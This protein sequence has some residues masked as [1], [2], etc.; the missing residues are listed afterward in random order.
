MSKT[1]I[2]TIYEGGA[3]DAA[4]IKFSPDKVVLIGV[5]KSD[6]ER[7][8]TLKKAIE[9]LKSKYKTIKFEMLD[10]SIYEIAK[11]VDDVCKVIDREH[12]LGNE[13]SLHISKGRRQQQSQLQQER[14]AV[15][16]LSM[17]S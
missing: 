6:P 1:L 5:D 3:T 7:K 15:S 9:T 12:K 2:S 4:I 11:I 17:M 8:T 16:S 10:T 14:P 13:I